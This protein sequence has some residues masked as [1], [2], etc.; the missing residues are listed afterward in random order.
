LCQLSPEY[1]DQLERL[2]ALDRPDP[3]EQLVLQVLLV[4]LECLAHRVVVL[5]DQM[6][7]LG[8]PVFL[9]LQV[10]LAHQA[11]VGPLGDLV[12]LELLDQPVALAVV[13]ILEML[14]LLETLA[15]LVL[16][17]CQDQLVPD[18]VEDLELQEQQEVRDRLVQQDSRGHLEGVEI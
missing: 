15:Q 17:D 1:P 10:L 14:V 2:V 5:L 16:P 12:P 4:R 9:D 7:L 18:P 8:R 11:L 3:P 13:G 6:G